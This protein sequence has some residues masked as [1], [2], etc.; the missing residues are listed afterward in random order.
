MAAAPPSPSR[1][2][3]A[4]FTSRNRPAKAFRVRSGSHALPPPVNEDKAT[5]YHRLRRRASV[6]GA[7]LGDVT[8]FA[9][10]VSGAAVR[11]REGLQA[12]SGSLLP[13]GFD[14]AATVALVT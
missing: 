13:A 7:I 4:A 10:V 1:R 6:C 2:P 8:L 14:E 3:T 9:L 12:A 5:R 11:M